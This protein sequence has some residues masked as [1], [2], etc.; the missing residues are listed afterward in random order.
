MGGKGE[1]EWGL[2]KGRETESVLGERKSEIINEKEDKW[3]DGG[4][5]DVKIWSSTSVH[6]GPERRRV[7][8]LHIHRQA[9]VHQPPRA[10]QRELITNTGVIRS[11]IPPL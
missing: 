10:T 2:G 4:K 3:M 6:T 1:R 11:S 8:V 5:V 9:L 7:R